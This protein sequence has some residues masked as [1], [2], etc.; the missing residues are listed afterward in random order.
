M[1]Q[2]WVYTSQKPRVG[3]SKERSI[4]EICKRRSDAATLRLSEV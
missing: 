3:R 2:G 4:F 1:M